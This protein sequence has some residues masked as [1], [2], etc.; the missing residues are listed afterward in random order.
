MN[1]FILFSNCIP[2]SGRSRSVICDLQKSQY[3]FIPNALYE[4][5]S[6]QKRASIEEIKERTNVSSEDLDEYISFLLSNEL[7]FL[8]SRDDLDRFPS[9]DLK[10]DV[11]GIITN[12]IID[13]D[14]HST[15]D[16]EKVFR[17]LEMLGC[18]HIQLRWFS[19]PAPEDLA[20]TLSFAEPTRINSIEVILSYTEAYTDA[21]VQ[22]LVNTYPRV[23]HLLFYNCTLTADSSF[24][25]TSFTELMLDPELH[26]GEISPVYFS[27]NMDTFTEGHEFNTCLNRKLSIN[28]HGEICNCPSL[29]TTFGNH[30]EKALTEVAVDAAFHEL[31][32]LNKKQIDV[33]RECEFRYICTDCRAFL[34]TPHDLFSKPLK[35]GYNPLTC[36]WSDWS[37]NPLKLAAASHYGV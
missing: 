26:C 31:W 32:R 35:C 7:G 36:E 23:Q 25:R 30:R 19:S 10:W 20:D 24:P 18:K 11:P 2:V 14:E 3:W 4:I 13:M 16:F 28:R 6:T 22:Q 12:S 29:K 5:L 21:V 1:F 33:C 34:E 9:V 15:H 17:E 27:V 37:K 8:G